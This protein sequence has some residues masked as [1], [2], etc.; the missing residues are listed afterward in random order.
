MDKI[1]MNEL[2]FY[3]YHGV[4]P[5]ENRLGQSFIISLVLGLSTKKAGKT[6][7]VKDTVSYAEVYQTVQ[8]IT[9]KRQF[10]LIEALAES[11]AAEVLNEYKLL[12][13]ITVKVI[14]PNPPIPGHYHSVAVEILRKRGK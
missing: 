2:S 8:Y 1:Y 12:D 11:I 13:E 10:K 3:G 7:S 14:K 5:E 4:L 6:D 9:E